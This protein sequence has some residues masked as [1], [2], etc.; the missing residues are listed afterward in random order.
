MTSWQTTGYLGTKTI[1]TPP[2]RP[3]PPPRATSRTAPPARLQ[4]PQRH[5]RAPVKAQ[6]RPAA[7]LQHMLCLCGLTPVPIKAPTIAITITI[8][9][10]T[11]CQ[12]PRPLP[13]LT[14]WLGVALLPLRHLLLLARARQC[15]SHRQQQRARLVQPQQ[16]L[17]PRPPRRLLRAASLLQV[18]AVLRPALPPLPRHIRLRRLSRLHGRRVPRSTVAR[19]QTTPRRQE[20]RSVPADA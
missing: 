7:N 13:R 3:P 1:C 5:P 20:S 14:R 15:H 2:E 19:L 11:P 18:S 6:G 8:T 17:P 4:P 12:L 9:T 10:V 16:L